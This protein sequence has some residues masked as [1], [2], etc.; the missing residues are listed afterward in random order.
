MHA[1]GLRSPYIDEN[2]NNRYW[3]FGGNTIVDVN[4]Q[5]RLTT[6]VPSQTGWLWSKQL[7]TASSWIVEFEFKVHSTNHNGL[8]GDGFAFWYV[9]DKEVDGPV[10][11]S[12]DE[13]EGLG[14]FFDTYAN[15]RHRV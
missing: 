15:G 13:F 8:F 4:K 5:I 1:F 3:N 9:K 12:K 6:E 11:G 7:L 10:F 2:L 14:V